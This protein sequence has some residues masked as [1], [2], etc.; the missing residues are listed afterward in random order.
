MHRLELCPHLASQEQE[1]SERRFSVAQGLP[2]ARAVRP[3]PSLKLSPNGV[4]HWACGAGASPQFCAA[5]PARHTVGATLAR[6]LGLT[7]HPMA[8]STAALRVSGDHLDPNEI[9]SFLGA[10]PSFSYRTG[11]LI[12]PGKGET[13]RKCGMWLLE[14]NDEEREDFAAQVDSILSKLSSDLGVWRAVGAKYQVDFYCGFFM[15]T[16]NQGFSLPLS[17]M[18]A[19]AQR[20]IEIGFDVYSPSPE[21]EAK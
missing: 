13:R 6:T 2:G 7:K 20:R 3:N 19:L 10:A 16:T 14:A 15:D 21:D 1:K 8:K 9:T 18:D 5:V 11:D 4:A 17:V 12:S